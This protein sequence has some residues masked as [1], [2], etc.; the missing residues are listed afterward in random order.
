MLPIACG[1]HG[2]NLLEDGDVSRRSIYFTRSLDSVWT[3]A[4]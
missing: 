1:T 4:F 2:G 3:G